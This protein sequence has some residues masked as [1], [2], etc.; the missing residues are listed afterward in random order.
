MQRCSDF[1]QGIRK[2]HLS[3]A[4]LKFDK[5]TIITDH[6]CNCCDIDPVDSGTVSEFDRVLVTHNLDDCFVILPPVC[7]LTSK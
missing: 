1:G 2:L 7:D 3:I 5:M 6:I 4:V